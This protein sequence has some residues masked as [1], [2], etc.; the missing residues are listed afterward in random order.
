MTKRN[1]RTRKAFTLLEILLVLAILV[2]LGGLAVV[3]FTGVQDSAFSDTAKTQI[4]SFKTM[5]DMYK[6]HTG[7]YPQTLQS[8]V[9]QP[10]D[11]PNP[12]KWQGPYTDEI[13]NDPWDNAYKY[14]IRQGANNRPDIH[15]YSLGPDGIDGTQDD[16][17][18]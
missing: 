4:G 10:S 2:V 12:A 17:T 13:P 18:S 5:V 7:R 8:L 16:V 14:E 3:N 6:L 11:L 15:I 9:S 1:R